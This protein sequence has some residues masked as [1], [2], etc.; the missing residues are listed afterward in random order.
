MS[1]APCAATR[2]LG[3]RGTGWV[4]IR[5]LEPG[6]GVVPA[7]A[8]IQ[9]GAACAPCRMRD[10]LPFEW[11]AASRFLREGRLQ[12]VSIMVGCRSA[13]ASSSSC[14]RRSPGSRRTS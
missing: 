8:P 12:T 9:P 4:E 3:L 13:S 6:D 10:W 1:G 7:A 5:S 2:S 14:R 11:I